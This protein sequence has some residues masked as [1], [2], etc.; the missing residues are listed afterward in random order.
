MFSLALS[1]SLP[2]IK[3]QRDK[4]W[5]ISPYPCIGGFSFL[6]LSFLKHPAYNTVLS[7]LRAGSKFLDLGCCVGQE[8]RKLAFDGAPPENMYGSDLRAGFL[9][10]GFELFCDES[11]WSAGTFF[12]A[13]I[14]ATGND[15]ED[16][17]EKVQG[18]IDIVHIA[19][20]LHLFTWEQQLQACVRITEILAP[21]PGCLIVGSQGG[22][23]QPR[24][25]PARRNPNRTTYLHDVE[26]FEKLWTEVGVKTGSEWKVKASLTKPWGE[27]GNTDKEPKDRYFN[28]D[29]A[30]W[31][32]FTVVRVS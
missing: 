11:K 9:S 32:T 16:A 17:L 24:E 10:L 8:L 31:L 21:K 23:I 7:R 20:F 26:S 18:K 12:A 5:A 15:T 30:R 22:S 2:L 27:R 25:A 28:G 4:A 1:F 29:D 6:R 14:F 3:E 19:M 13:D